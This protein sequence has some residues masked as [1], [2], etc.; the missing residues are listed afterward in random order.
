MS[1]PAP[2]RQARQAPFVLLLAV[3]ACSHAAMAMAQVA[4]PWFVL[5]QSN[6]ATL[7][8]LVMLV[9]FAPAFVGSWIGGRWIDRYGAA[10]ISMASELVSAAALVLLAMLA[11]GAQLSIALLVAL[12]LVLALV[13]P[14][15]FIAREAM[16]PA[17]ARL[18]R[19]P[20][21]R[22]NA[23]R[24]GTTQAARIVAPLSAG[25]IITTLGMSWAWVAIG[26]AAVGAAAFNG[27]LSWQRAWRDRPPVRGGGSAAAAAGVMSQP[28]V[29]RLL[30]VTVPLVAI[31]EP[32][33]SVVLPTAVFRS[34]QSA[35][36]LGGLDSAFN[37]GA[38]A[39]AA[40]YGWRGAHLSGRALL[41]A[42]ALAVSATLL[43]FAAQAPYVW[44]FAAAL[45]CG[46]AGGAVGPYLATQLQ[47]RVPTALRG[48][49]LAA[50]AMFEM[51][52]AV[53]GIALS[54]ALI[55]RVGSA[56]LLV[57]FAALALA[58]AAAAWRVR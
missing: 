6:D 15:G 49:A 38:L 53:V 29:R 43:V 37:V 30:W 5:E 56:G 35:L 57:G 10:R 9:L 34:G 20:L 16:T 3:E 36:S 42:C 47:T 28:I 18:A 39:G 11:I 25:A 22:A 13:D 27:A 58:V 1:K 50:M 33:E 17:L 12:L 55:E 41:M 51:G 31:D 4:L 54:A 21:A 7:M 14:A 19:V 32:L 48:R 44:L 45:L 40:L 23:L 46:A 2:P 26:V 8:G 24:E 52:G